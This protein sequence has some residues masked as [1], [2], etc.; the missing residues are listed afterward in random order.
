[1][2]NC[3][4]DVGINHPTQYYRESRRIADE[5]EAAA[6]GKPGDAAPAAAAAVLS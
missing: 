6:G 5:H 1:M 3:S 4:C 2:H